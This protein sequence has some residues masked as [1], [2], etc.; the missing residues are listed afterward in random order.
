MVSI[1]EDSSV[2]SRSSPRKFHPYELALKELTSLTDDHAECPICLETIS[3][4]HVVPECLHRFCGYCIKEA[5]RKCNNE[6]PECRET[7]PT[8]RHLRKDAKFD[9]FVSLLLKMML[10]N[11]S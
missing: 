7:I 2:S 5:L 1:N 10:K 9:T 4:A 6:C 3:H 8:K 11:L